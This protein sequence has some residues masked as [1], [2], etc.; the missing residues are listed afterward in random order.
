MARFAFFGDNLIS[1]LEPFWY[2]I[3]A[4]LPGEVRFF[5]RD[6]MK[7]TL[8]DVELLDEMIDF[9]P[10]FVFVHIGREDIDNHSEPS[11]IFG[12][13]VGIVEKLKSEGVKRVFIGDILPKHGLVDAD[14]VCFERQA[15]VV[16]RRLR[17]KFGDAFIKFSLSKIGLCLRNKYEDDEPNHMNERGLK[18]YFHTVKRVF[19]SC[20][21][22][23]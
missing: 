20:R 13:I 2:N 22:F 12:R 3:D 1:R 21:L 19:L 16:N 18:A 6:D 10:D 8:L 14:H 11:K 4:H 17:K 23:A 9:R 15:K 7:T 5:S